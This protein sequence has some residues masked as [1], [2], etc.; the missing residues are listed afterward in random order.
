[1][2]SEVLPSPDFKMQKKYRLICCEIGTLELG[3]IG[4]KI[5]VCPMM[6][7]NCCLGSV[8]KYGCPLLIDTTKQSKP[9]DFKFGIF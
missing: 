1:M 8:L 9:T 3:L 4:A 5:E 2:Q 6:P 7:E